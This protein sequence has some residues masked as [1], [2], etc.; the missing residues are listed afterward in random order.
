MVKATL[1][2]LIGEQKPKCKVGFHWDAAKGMCV[3]DNKLPLGVLPEVSPEV[4]KVTEKPKSGPIDTRQSKDTS[5]QRV[6]PDGTILSSS[7]VYKP[8]VETQAPE[9]YRDN[10][11]GE[12]S[13]VRLPSGKTILG[14]SPEEVN[15]Y[16]SNYQEPRTL[17]AGSAEFG[18]AEAQAQQDAEAAALTAQIGGEISGEVGAD[19]RPIT[20]EGEVSGLDYKQI[21]LSTAADA[22]FWKSV[23]LYGGIGATAGAKL[24]TVVGAAA[25]IPTGGLSI[26]AATA[27]G[28]GVGGAL[29]IGLAVYEGIQS[30]IEAQKKGILGTQI[31]TVAK[32]ERVSKLAISG[33]NAFPEL[34]HLYFQEFQNAQVQI[35]EAHTQMIIDVRSN[36]N[37]ALGIDGT[38]ELGKFNLY[39]EHTQPLLELEMRRALG[40]PN[41]QQGYLGLMMAAESLSQ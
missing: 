37:L 1:A 40:A 17:P 29:G 41:E 14:M 36:T 31:D 18:T 11:T 25:A 26:P 6:A 4:K 35:N 34:K 20:P 9:V 15:N 3:P 32:M 12:I 2:K 33:A 16:I 5:K 19:G 27:I 24:G 38:R 23:G 39:E 8:E 10:E 21:V 28:A 30:N 7:A 22:G 13:G